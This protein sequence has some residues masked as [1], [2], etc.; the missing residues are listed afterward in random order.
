MR[1]LFALPGL[2][3][4]DRGAEIAFISVA[5]ELAKAGHQVTLLGS[6]P[7]KPGTLY[8][9][10]HA[11][12]W[13]ERISPNFLHCPSCETIARMKSLR[14]FHN[15]YSV[16]TPRTTTSHSHAV[17]RLQIGSFVVRR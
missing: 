11:E 15:F 8:R 7:P 10:I 3:R 6:G 12:I 4:I 5:N 17:I 13:S 2:H 9:F 1:V 14:L 16:I